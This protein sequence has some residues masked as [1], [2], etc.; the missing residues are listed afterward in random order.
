M[1]MKCGSATWNLAQEQ[2]A[3]YDTGAALLTVTVSDT[4]LLSS[5]AG[6][7]ATTLPT[8]DE[9]IAMARAVLGI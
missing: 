9:I 2:A 5:P 1:S 3:G 8:D 7:T 4:D 6:S